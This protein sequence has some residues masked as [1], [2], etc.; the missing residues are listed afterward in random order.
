M[1]RAYLAEQQKECVILKDNLQDFT[2]AC[3]ETQSKIDSIPAE[4]IDI[5]AINSDIRSRE[6]K[7]T[8]L[9]IR[10]DRNEEELIIKQGVYKKIIDFLDVFELQKFQQLKIEIES[11]QLRLKEQ[12]DNLDKLTEIYEDIIKKQKLLE[13]HEYDPDCVYCSENEF[14]KEAQLAV[15]RKTDIEAEQADILCTI[16]M[17]SE[18]IN[19]LNPREV[20][21]QLERHAKLETNKNTVSSVF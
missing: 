10:N 13:E 5:A 16:N 9:K 21:T 1:T 11:N 17:I 18:E 12:E 8:S 19:S 4:I 3:N 2:A 7:I 6:N 15:S 14:V 20:E